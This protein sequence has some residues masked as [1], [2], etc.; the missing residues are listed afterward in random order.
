MSQGAR[1]VRVFSHTPPPGP[2]TAAT[3]DLHDV[4]FMALKQPAPTLA[5]EVTP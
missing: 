5:T 3:P 2:F 4:Y 1:C